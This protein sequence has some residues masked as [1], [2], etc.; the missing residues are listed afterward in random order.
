M[1]MLKEIR[2]F[3]GFSQAILAQYLGISRGLLAMAET[4]KRDLQTG[5]YIKLG[6]LASAIHP[7]DSRVRDTPSNIPTDHQKNKLRDFTNKNLADLKYKMMVCKRA[8]EGMKRKHDQALRALE[9]FT[10]LAKTEDPDNRLYEVMEI[11]ARQALEKQM[12]WRSSGWRC[13]LRD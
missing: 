8:L 5:L 3:Y 12:R 7:P 13:R 10:G 2:A 6:K 1:K 9:T 11:T 4:G